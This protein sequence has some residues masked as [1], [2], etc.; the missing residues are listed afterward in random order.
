MHHRRHHASVEPQ[1]IVIRARDRREF[2][3]ALEFFD[4]ASRSGLAPQ[5]IV[6][7]DVVRNRLRAASL[8]SAGAR[9][10]TLRKVDRVVL[11]RQP[12][13]SRSPIRNCSLRETCAGRIG[14][15]IRSMFRSL[16]VYVAQGEKSKAKEPVG[17]RSLPLVRAAAGQPALFVPASPQQRRDGVVALGPQMYLLRRR[18]SGTVEP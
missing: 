12:R 1:Q 16:R 6:L 2:L 3:R 15:M 7:V 18:R 13:H 10:G 11:Q 8:I 14:H 4:N 17:R 5:V 9:S